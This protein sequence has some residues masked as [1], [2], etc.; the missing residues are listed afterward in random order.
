M[1]IKL[2]KNTRL[3]KRKLGA[4]V[5]KYKKSH[6]ATGNSNFLLFRQIDPGTAVVLFVLCQF[7]VLPEIIECVP[8][9]N[10]YLSHFAD[11][12]S[13]LNVGHG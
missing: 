5:C 11:F 1:N 13:K 7:Y 9:F 6:V 3:N 10:L 2:K 4:P 8:G 12:R